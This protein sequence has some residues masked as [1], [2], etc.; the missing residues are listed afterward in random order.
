MARA[1]IRRSLVSLAAGLAIAAAAAR[2][3]FA[4]AVV[5]DLSSH[6]IGI[7][8]GFTGA[9]VVLFGATDGPGDIIVVV[10]GPPRNITVRHKS[11]V[12]GIWVNTREITFTDVPGFY[13]VASARPLAEV[14]SPAAA[15][16]H[17]IGLAN[18]DLVA[19]PAAPSGSETAFGGGLIGEQRRRGLFRQSVGDIKFLGGRLF[20][21]AIDFPS[22]V[23]TGT[24]R[25]RVFLARTKEVV[26]AQT[27]P[28]TISKT[29]VDAAVFDFAH[30][31]AAIYGLLAVLTA[32]VAG[33]LS[34]LPFRN[35]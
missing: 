16:S 28:L 9:S 3:T 32:V 12:L 34:S 4:E 31:E 5:A 8:A 35:A 7:T 6:L 30:N 29:G 1:A 14:V 33:W 22:N 11:K 10:R 2:P 23:P 20:H 21:A 24:Y 15:A 19:D 27:I 13:A 25:V 17:H 26:A 18:L